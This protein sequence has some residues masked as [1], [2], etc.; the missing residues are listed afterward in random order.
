MNANVAGKAEITIEWGG[1]E[2]PSIKGSASG[3][4]S[5]DSGNKAE[6]KVEVESNGSGKATVSVEHDE[7]SDS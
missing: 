4:V 5:D 6:V 2:G 3:S 1:K 7:K